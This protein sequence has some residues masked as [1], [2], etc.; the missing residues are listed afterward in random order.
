MRAV[1]GRMN[2]VACES[3]SGQDKIAL[4]ANK[5]IALSA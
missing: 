4:G 1:D 3:W 2:F 5:Y